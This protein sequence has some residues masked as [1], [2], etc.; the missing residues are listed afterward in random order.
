MVAFG[1]N[2]MHL[3]LVEAEHVLAWRSEDGD[4][5]W[6]FVLVV[7]PRA[8]RLISRNRYRLATR[9]QRLGMLAMGPGSLVM[10]R[11][12]LR[13]IRSRAECLASRSPEPAGPVTPAGVSS[14]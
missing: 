11:R 2:R 6:T 13:G 5:V 1:S 4:W 14:D 10:E 9:S 12:M 8:T 7:G 3:E